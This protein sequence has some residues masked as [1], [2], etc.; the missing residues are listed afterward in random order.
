MLCG[1]EVITKDG[2]VTVFYLQE[3]SREKQVE[4]RTPRH[5]NGADTID[6]WKGVAL[7]PW[8]SKH[9]FNNWQSLRFESGDNYVVRFHRAEL[10]TMPG[11]ITLEQNGAKLDSTEVRIIFPQQRERFWIRDVARIYLEDFEVAPRP[12]QI[13]IGSNFNVPLITNP[14]PFRG[15]SA[16]RMADLMTSV[17]FADVGSVILVSKDGSR[18]RLEYPKHLEGSILE[19]DSNGLLNFKSPTIPTGMWLRD[20]VY[21]QCGPY[22]ILCGNDTRIDEIAKILEWKSS[23]QYRLLE[24]SAKVYSME[25]IQRLR[26]I[27]S[28]RDLWIEFAD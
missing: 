26:L 12:R 18:L 25:E 11:Y 7:I 2:D 4:Y 22:A 15:I 14:E 8:L 17:F 9:K 5:K 3:L 16:Y 23:P 1:I 19:R 21:I 13:S 20:V 10:D 28:Q 6:Y 24:P 27:T